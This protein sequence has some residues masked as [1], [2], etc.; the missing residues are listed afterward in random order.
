MYLFIY[1]YTVYIYIQDTNFRLST[2]RLFTGYAPLDDP[3]IF[4]LL[5]LTCRQG[6]K[7]QL[8]EQMS[9]LQCEAPWRAVERDFMRN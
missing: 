5:V 7:N 2:T 3:P 8:L 1:F 9:L 4:F 6:E